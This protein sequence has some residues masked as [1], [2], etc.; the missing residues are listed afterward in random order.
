MKMTITAVKI[1]PESYE[2]DQPIYLTL[3]GN[4]TTWSVKIGDCSTPSINA[5]KMQA[6]TDA[7][8]E[9]I[10]RIRNA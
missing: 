4:V 3:D 9:T 10:D 1:V 2:F 8:N 7:I 6:M 5:N